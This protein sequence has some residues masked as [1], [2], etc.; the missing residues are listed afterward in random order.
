[1]TQRNCAGMMPLEE[2]SEGEE[3]VDDSP[4][5]ITVEDEHK[6]E[7]GNLPQLNVLE[8]S[9]PVIV[10][11]EVVIDV[12]Q[13]QHPAVPSL[14]GVFHSFPDFSDPELSLSPPAAATEAGAIEASATETSATETPATETPDTEAPATEALTIPRD[15]AQ[16]GN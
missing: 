2:E 11:S 9:S 10:T 12:P 6:E 7:H 16:K 4:L 5:V 13:D 3:H 15:S 1:M 14:L 8:E